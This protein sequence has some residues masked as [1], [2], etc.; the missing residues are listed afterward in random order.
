MS[1]E[2]QRAVAGRMSSGLSAFE[3]AAQQASAPRYGAESDGDDDDDMVNIGASVSRSAAWGVVPSE[4]ADLPQAAA[5]ASSRYG[6]ESDDDDD[7]DDLVNTGASVS[8]SGSRSQAWSTISAAAAPAVQGSSGAELGKNSS[9]ATVDYGSDEFIEFDAEQD[10]DSDI[11][12]EAGIDGGTVVLDDISDDDVNYLRQNL[13][14]NLSASSEVDEELETDDG[15]ADEALV[16]EDIAGGSPPRRPTAAP[17]HSP[18]RRGFNSA[19]G[20]PPT[21]TNFHQLTA[22]GAC[23][24]EEIGE[25]VVAAPPAVRAEPRMR[26]MQRPQGRSQHGRHG[27]VRLRHILCISMDFELNPRARLSLP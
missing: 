2:Q 1:R 6:G 4:A 10:S 9:S 22:V 17:H 24:A 8:L 20:V 15:L 19:S 13:N 3:A 12:I 7:D 11:S 26:P 23:C 25:V 16:V 18:S 27:H 21:A 5:Q 14:R